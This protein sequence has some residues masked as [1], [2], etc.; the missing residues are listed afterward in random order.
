MNQNNFNKNIQLWSHTCPQW[1][2]VV[3]ELKCEH[4]F[5]ESVDDQL[6]IYKIQ[7]GN[8]E[9]LY[10]QNPFDEAQEWFSSLN[11]HKA[12]VIYVYG[13]GLG[14]YFEAAKEWLKEE[15][16]F[17]IFLE[18]NLEVIRCF[19]ETEYANQLLENKQVRIYAFNRSD[20]SDHTLADVPQLF[21]KH[22][23][24][25]TA[26]QNYEKDP[27]LH[28]INADISFWS[29]YR[30]LSEQEFSSLGYHF[31][32]NFYQNVLHLPEAYRGNLLFEKFKG[33]PAIICGAGPSLDKNLSI[34][35][36]LADKAL[37][38]AG[39]TSMNA[40]NSRGF[41]PH[42][43]VGIDPNPAQLTRL[44]MNEA[45]EVPYFYR[46][47]LYNKALT[48]IQG[49]RL[50]VTGSGGYHI[51][52]WIETELGI[53]GTDV[54][55]GFNVVNFSLA[56]AVA[57]GCNPIIFVGLDLA[58]TNMKSYQSGVASHPTHDRRRDFRTKEV[59]EDLI[60]KLDIYGQPIFTLW[61]WVS[62][63]I[64]LSNFVNQNTDTLFLNATEGGIGIPGVP[65]KPLSEVV[66]YLLIRKQD[67]FLRVHG[68]IQNALM[69]TSVTKTHIEELF[70]LLHTSLKACEEQCEQLHVKA[71][72]LAEEEQPDDAQLEQLLR[73]LHQEMGYKHV[74]IDLDQYYQPTMGL[75]LQQIAYDVLIYGGSQTSKQM[76]LKADHF[77]F[78]KDAATLN[79]S[80]IDLD[81]L[82]P[83]HA[84]VR[85]ENKVDLPENPQNELY[86]F[87]EKEIIISDAQLG[88]SIHQK[89]EEPIHEEQ[90]F[91][92]DGVLKLSQFFIKNEL[93]GPC[94]FYGKQGQ[95]LGCSW[96]VNGIRQGNTLLNYQSGS[97]YSVQPFVNG[98]RQGKHTFYFDNGRA[99]TILNYDN[100]LLHGEV[101]LYYPTG[102]PKRE[103]N[104]K[105]GK[106]NGV[107]RMWD[108]DTGHLILEAEYHE[109]NPVGY[110]RTWHLNGKLAQEVKYEENGKVISA[111]RW[112]VEGSRILEEELDY[113]DAVAKHVRDLTSSLETVWTELNKL[114]PL[115]ALPKEVAEDINSNLKKLH[116]AI[117]GL[118]KLNTL[119]LESVGLQGEAVLE[120]IWKSPVIQ[121]EL[122]KKMQMLTKTLQ[123]EIDRI[124]NVV[125]MAKKQLSK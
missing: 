43:G 55:E 30:K 65:N 40:V 123:L 32:N 72:R 31:F 100:D 51:S 83:P 57:M 56:L 87:N 91:Y 44:V 15:N 95:V 107:E 97:Q 109:G 24:L 41:L 113:F 23:F 49:P 110:A 111:E 119:L 101:K 34:L 82:R 105:H 59:K 98:K 112:T 92:E 62:E 63:S 42:F 33:V 75:D 50:Y 88:L 5:L 108:E 7:D 70:R 115:L 58:Y 73:T 93:W 104:F 96:Y 19:L 53:E 26:L 38:F 17:L 116:E 77:K 89:L 80:L 1:A 60:E 27:L 39:G 86:S 121:E 22:D 84:Y 69:P 12:K 54:E 18:N 3:K 103:L 61:K 29:H 36:Q 48:I 64:W 122:Q 125:V 120:P 4:Y 71:L 68:E 124:K 6:N 46:N 67:L 76:K 47:R 21:G 85:P 79:Y 94:T 81:I 13:L 35:E 74:L 66:N 37:I 52:K 102:W 14:Y 117:G 106:R 25:V 78:L 16:H 2:E 90:L 28:E 118:E 20:S 8:K 9:F 99:K 114:A 11:L 45:Y 10:S